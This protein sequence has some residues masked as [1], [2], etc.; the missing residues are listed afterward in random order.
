MKSKNYLTILILFITFSFVLAQVKPNPPIEPSS[1]GL[2]LISCDDALGWK[3]ATGSAMQSS[4]SLKT[5]TDDFVEGNASLE[6]KVVHGGDSDKEYGNWTD[7]SW[8]FPS[9]LNIGDAT[10]IRFWLKV[11]TP[12][13]N[14]HAFQF[15]CDLTDDLNGET[16]LWRWAEDRDIFYVKNA[17]EW[18]EIVIPISRLDVPSWAGPKHEFQP[19]KIIKFAFGIHTNLRR[20]SIAIL[21]DDIRVTKQKVIGTIAA[22]DNAEGVETFNNNV[23]ENTIVVKT[24]TDDFLEP[25]NS[26]LDIQ[27]NMLK[28]PASWGSVAMATVRFPN[29]V[30]VSG[31]RELR[32]WMKLL[33]GSKQIALPLDSTDVPAGAWFTNIIGFIDVLDEEGQAET[34]R[35]IL[36]G[37]QNF[38]TNEVMHMKLE[39]P[40][41]PQPANYT[42]PKW[43]EFVVPIKDFDQWDWMSHVNPYINLSKISGFAFGVGHVGFTKDVDPKGPSLPDTIRVLLNNL[44]ATADD[45]IVTSVENKN[46]ELP[47]SL[48]LYDNYP[49]PF[50]PSTNIKFELPEE[51]IVSLK[52][53]DSKGEE[54]M[55][56]VNN[57]YKLRGSYLYKVDMSKFSSGVYYYTLTHNSSRITKKMLLIK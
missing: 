30:D 12:T 15:T 46:F 45:D 31:A 16:G 18:R 36:G 11:K 37:A 47:T 53:Y 57:T 33:D 29:V 3:T 10:E 5:N 13:T 39:R 34:W 56:V 17:D 14:H 9:P 23:A 7:I 26:S 55:T 35:Y 6:V 48:R 49:N 44:Y 54:V 51:G 1:K 40:A 4:V 41:D 24:N 43:N 28:A 27:F 20:D 21:I 38:T 25:N 52:I 32:F 22:L 50:N 19:S 2:Q 42:N 8:D